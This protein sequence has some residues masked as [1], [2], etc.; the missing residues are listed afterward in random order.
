MEY[1]YKVVNFEEECKAGDVRNKTAGKKIASQLELIMQ[2]HSREG[3]ELQGQYRFNVDV[4]P[5][6]FDFILKLFGQST[7]DGDYRIEQLVFRKQK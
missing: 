6:C 3:W 1:E 4:K 2:Q 7:V 5:A